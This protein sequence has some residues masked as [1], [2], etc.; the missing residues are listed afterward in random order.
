MLIK[1]NV[2]NFGK[3]LLQFNSLLYLDKYKILRASAIL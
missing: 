1:S 3:Y 2:N